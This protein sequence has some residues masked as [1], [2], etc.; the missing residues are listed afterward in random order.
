MMKKLLFSTCVAFFAMTMVIKAQ[1]TLIPVTDTLHYYFNKHYFKTGTTINNFPYY[2]S[3]AATSTVLTHVGSR[4]ETKDTIV[5]TGLEAFAKMGPSTSQLKIKVTLYLCNLDGSN[6]PILPAIDSVSQDVFGSTNAYNVIGGNFAK[7][8]KIAKD[9]AVLFRNMSTVKGD[10]VHLMRTAGMTYTAWP[11]VAWNKKYSDSYG[12]A[13][14]LGT[15]VSTK[16]LNLPAYNFAVG[17]DYEFCVA[18]RV[19]YTLTANHIQPNEVVSQQTVCTFQALT[20]QNASSFHFTHRMFN[21]LEFYKKWNLLS[22]LV[23]Q[24]INGGWPADSSIT[25][26]FLDVDRG[27]TRPD[28]RQFLPYGGGNN[29]IVHYSDSADCFGGC[30][31]RA[32]LRSMGIYGRNTSVPYRGNQDFLLC[33]DYCNGDA[34][35]ISTNQSYAKLMVYPN[36]V[37]NG[38]STVKG[39]VGKNSIDVYDM[40]GQ[41]V[42]H[43]MT[44]QE[45]VQID[46][47]KL[48]LGNYV[49]RIAN[50]RNQNKTLKLQKAE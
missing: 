32:N 15:F 12:Y 46:L 4:F 16:D 41:L 37:N 14:K 18:P 35:G 33:V 40:L 19:Q 23:G 11:A 20:Y 27:P 50:D 9:Y 34:A 44:E 10:T 25:W 2:K 6:M 21:L 48:A 3:A 7:P 36:P 29:Q 47:S 28:P 26:N 42:H 22:P 1:A 39:L 8:R 5:I 24:P 43:E 45:S 17:T 49:I 38:K 13:R 31:F 30:Q